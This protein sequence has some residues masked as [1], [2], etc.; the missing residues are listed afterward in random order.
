MLPTTASH[1]SLALENLEFLDLSGTA[2]TDAGLTHLAGLKELRLVIL[3]RTNVSPAGR[4][5]L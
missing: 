5:A 4:I 2:V 3:E 1:V